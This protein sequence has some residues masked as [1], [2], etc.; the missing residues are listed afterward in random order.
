[1]V[2]GWLQLK[3]TKISI[4]KNTN[5]ST[6]QI[7]ILFFLIKKAT[8][9]VLR[10]EVVKKKFFIC[11]THY[12]FNQQSYEIST[13]LTSKHF[14]INHF[15]SWNKGNSH[16]YIL[17]L[18]AFLFLINQRYCLKWTIISNMKDIHTYNWKVWQF[19]ESVS[20]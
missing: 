1:M 3:Y 9:C 10:G 14:L 6:I 7:F 5:K 13:F 4:P 16:N 19:C 12:V 2:W 8:G 20:W 11:R 18:I 17:L 15:F